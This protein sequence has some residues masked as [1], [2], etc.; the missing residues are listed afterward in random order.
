MEFTTIPGVY[1]TPGPNAVGNFGSVTWEK[2]TSNIMSPQVIK[3]KSS[4][5]HL[6]AAISFKRSSALL[7][8]VSSVQ[9]RDSEA[10]KA[11]AA[12]GMARLDLDTGKFDSLDKVV[13]AL[14][15]LGLKCFGVY[16]TISH[17]L[18]EDC[19]CKWRVLIPFRSPVSYEMWHAVQAYIFSQI[20][21]RD[22][23]CVLKPAQFM[24]LPAHVEGAPYEQHVEN[25]RKLSIL[26]DIFVDALAY[27]K[28]LQRLADEQAAAAAKR[29]ALQPLQRGP[30]HAGQRSIIATLDKYMPWDDLLAHYGYISK[31]APCGCAAWLFPGSTTGNPGVRLLKGTDGRE[32]VVSYHSD[33]VLNQTRNGVTYSLDKLDAIRLLENLPNEAAA[34][35]WCGE[36][37]FPEITKANQRD[38]AIG[39]EEEARARWEAANND[40]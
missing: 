8:G 19:L 18:T 32:R 29:K 12:F 28:E 25:G 37:L 26:D 11:E 5:N 33:D 22:D 23:R 14:R 7:I 17:R 3:S 13:D 4:D 34:V 30:M 35:K 40:Q 15:A 9:S 27:A 16:S 24:F 21:D 10:L 31:P 1:F 38:Y 36:N 2:V 20:A 6:A 39:K